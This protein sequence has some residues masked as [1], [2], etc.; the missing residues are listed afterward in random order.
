MISFEFDLND[1]PIF[2]VETFSQAGIRNHFY[3]VDMPGQVRDKNRT[4][5]R[6]RRR[7]EDRLECG[8]PAKGNTIPK[9]PS[10]SIRF[11]GSDIHFGG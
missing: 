7:L 5:N 1:C 3:D 10:D 4:W 6:S 11:K 8:S 2:E 9:E